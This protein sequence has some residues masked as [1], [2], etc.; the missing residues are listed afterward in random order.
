MQQAFRIDL[1]A[2]QQWSSLFYVL[3]ALWSNTVCCAAASKPMSTAAMAGRTSATGL[4]LEVRPS[5]L[6]AVTDD[7]FADL[8]AIDTSIMDDFQPRTTP[9]VPPS[10]PGLSE[11]VFR[12]INE[13]LDCFDK[14]HKLL[15]RYQMLGQNERRT[16]GLIPSYFFFCSV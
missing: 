15:G 11:E 5:D 16:G 13:Q 2:Y 12:Y 4:Q 3:G 6:A 1:Q 9:P 14:Q 7:T 8:T 10:D